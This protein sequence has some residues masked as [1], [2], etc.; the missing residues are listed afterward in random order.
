MLYK[1]VEFEL[2]AKTVSLIVSH[3][4]IRE[5]LNNS[6]SCKVIRNLGE[7]MH[8]Q[9]S[10]YFIG[11]EQLKKS[12]ELT[13]KKAL[14]MVKADR[15]L[16]KL[17]VVQG[18][19]VLYAGQYFIQVT[20]PIKKGRFAGFVLL[21]D[22]SRYSQGEYHN[23]FR[24]EYARA[25]SPEQLAKALAKAKVESDK[26]ANAVRLQSLEINQNLQKSKQRYEHLDY[27]YRNLKQRLEN[28]QDRTKG[29]ELY[30]H[31]LEA[32]LNECR[33]QLKSKREEV[34]QMY[35]EE[36]MLEFAEFCKG[37]N[38]DNWA[39]LIAE[40]AKLKYPEVKE[41]TF[42]VELSNGLKTTV[43]FRE[44]HE[45]TK[46]RHSIAIGLNSFLSCKDACKVR[47]YPYPIPPFLDSI[48]KK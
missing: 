43:S 44:L 3:E 23:D 10:N 34:K 4:P 40:F 8:L 12:V 33:N 46:P 19:T 24:E 25:I 14:K 39:T 21:S 37:K 41:P 30:I 47:E 6:T 1:H 2:G 15:K 17:L 31:S 27:N 28:E 29:Q 42:V 20:A 18:V 13:Y 11:N 16:K 9:G 22:A 45:L 36:D 7:S 26:A 32:D 48:L 35:T 5:D 38:L